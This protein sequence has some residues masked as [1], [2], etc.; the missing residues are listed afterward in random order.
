MTTTRTGSYPIGFRRGWSDWQKNLSN[1]ARWARENSFSAID[2]ARLTA[3]DLQILKSNELKLGSVDLLDFGKLMDNDAGVRKDLLA[4]NLDY[5]R[6]SSE[7][8]AN[9]FFTCIIPGDPAR[10][11]AENYALAVE[12]FTPIAQACAKAGASLA[13]E[14]W[15]GGT[16]HLANLCCTPETT[17]AFLKDVGPGCGLNYDPSHLLRLAC[18]PL[19][20]LKEFLPHVKHVHAKDTQ[21]F[22]DVLYEL[23]TQPATFAKPHGFGE[24]T[25]RYTIPGD[26]LVKWSEIFAT[27]K[28][29]GFNGIVSVELEDE[30]YN[31]S[32][33]GEKK[34]LMKSLE[35]LKQA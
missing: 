9:I 1:L 31:G 35:F 11:R 13:I 29:G 7:L 26:G 16:P 8:G 19:R 12:V 32:E 18:D 21:L 33:E 34:G 5:I 25:W 22:T 6:A 28:S 24:W 2:L 20:F 15:P 27:L 17:R 14:G 3:E 4:R 30:N 10:K 23:G